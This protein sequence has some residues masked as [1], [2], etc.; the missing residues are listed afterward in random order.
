MTKLR[1]NTDPD[2]FHIFMFRNPVE[3]YNLLHNHK[4]AALC[5]LVTEAVFFFK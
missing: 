5:F 3:F 2:L 4:V 1:G